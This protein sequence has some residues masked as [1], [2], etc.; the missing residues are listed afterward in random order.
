MESARL[1]EPGV[2]YFL[3]ETLKNCHKEKW[4]YN[5]LVI[6][7][8]LLILLFIIIYFTLY[9]FNNS[10]NISDKEK[11]EK[12]KIKQTYFLD[13]IK[14]MSEKNNRE[15]NLSITNLPKFE[16]EFVHYDKKFI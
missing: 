11:K 15:F 6:N 12:E 4:R 5:N 9:Y 7:G 16:N 2:S 1:I 13:K 14:E 8:V 10:K 3:E